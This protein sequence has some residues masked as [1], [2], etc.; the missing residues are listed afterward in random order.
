[1][2]IMKIIKKYGYDLVLSDKL[3]D[4]SNCVLALGN[5]DG[6]HI[7]HATLFDAAKKL[8]NDIGANSVGV[9]CFG[10]TG[11]G[12]M[13]RSGTQSIV[14][15]EER[16]RLFL[17]HGMDFAVVCDFEHFRSMSPSEFMSSHMRDSLGCSGAVCGQNFR[18]GA[19]RSGDTKNLSDFF[20]EDNV[21]IVDMLSVCGAVV[22]STKIREFIQNGDM[23]SARE[24]LGK[25]FYINLPVSE[26]KRLGRRIGFPTANQSFPI[27]CIIPKYGIYA[28]VCTTQGG[29]RYIGVSNVGVRPTI[30]DGTDSHAVN[31]ETYILDFDG[32]VYNQNLKIEFYKLLREEKR[33]DSVELLAQAISSDAENARS[34][35]ESLG[36]EL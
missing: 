19:G 26:G 7:A 11:H 31:C 25:P 36:V 2:Q 21:R 5:F 32:N 10:H 34:Y 16:V 24:F 27:G 30:I 15:T 12:S 6:V 1:M 17:E 33:F 14:S 18:F 28:T 23:E 20:G 13:T 4:T 9:C 29:K 22:S 35:I 8:K 3:S